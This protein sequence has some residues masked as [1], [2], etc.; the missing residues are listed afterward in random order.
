MDAKQF[1]LVAVGRALI[2]NPAW[3]DMVQGE[4]HEELKPFRKEHLAELI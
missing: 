4:R 1:E 2:S 3:V